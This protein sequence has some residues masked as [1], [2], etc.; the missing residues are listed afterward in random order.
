MS[1][2]D[3]TLYKRTS[4]AALRALIERGILWPLERHPSWNRAQARSEGDAA[5]LRLAAVGTDPDDWQAAVNEARSM[6]ETAGLA[7]QENERTRPWFDPDTMTVTADMRAIGFNIVNPGDIPVTGNPDEI[8][9][10][11]A[12]RWRA[13]AEP[14]AGGPA[15]NGLTIARMAIYATLPTEE[16]KLMPIFDDPSWN[17]HIDAHD[18]TPLEAHTTARFLTSEDITDPADHC[19]AMF[20]RTL[21]EIMQT[22]GLGSPES[23]QELATELAS[24]MIRLTDT[25]EA[26]RKGVAEPPQAEGP[27]AWQKGIAAPGQSRGHTNA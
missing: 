16:A 22:T 3:L 15:V 26:L 20:G 13:L 21:T 18:G 9:E 17:Y 1:R 10:K 12:P 27:M 19:R 7:N 25:G 2:T 8:L 11:I 5:K 24:A 4:E 6:G 23:D 14:E